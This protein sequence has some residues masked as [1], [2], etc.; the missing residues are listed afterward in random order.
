MNTALK[1]NWLL[2]WANLSTKE[3]KIALEKF[4]EIVEDL[5]DSLAME[6]F[7]SWWYKILSKKESDEF[8]KSL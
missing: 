2:N 8:F 6:R 3:K 1:N 7:N 5:E 4:Y